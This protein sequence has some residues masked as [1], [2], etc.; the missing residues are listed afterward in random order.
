VTRRQNRVFVVLKLPQSVPALITTARAI[1]DRCRKH[2][3]LKNPKPSLAEVTA[4][5]DT[6]SRAEVDKQLGGHGKRDA[7]DHA[8]DNV[9]EA[10]QALAKCVE[11]QANRNLATAESFVAE[12][13]MSTRAGSS[14]RKKPFTVKPGP[15]PGSV[16]VEVIAVDDAALYRWFCSLDGGKTFKQ[17]TSTAQSKTTLTGLPSGVEVHFYCEATGRDGVPWTSETLTLRVK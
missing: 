2:A 11:T 15:V 6:L 12:A 7:R 3:G 17:W 4:L 8:A 9:R 10:L 14:R 16:I 13:G 1:L 5:V